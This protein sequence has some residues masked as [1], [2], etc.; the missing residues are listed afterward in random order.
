MALVE[1]EDVTFSYRPGRPVLQAISFQMDPGERVALLGPNGAGKSTL[2][3]H[4]NG[5]VRGEGLVRIAGL[6]VGSPRL[7][8]IRSQ[9]GL[10]FQDPDDQLFCSTVLQDVAYGLR[11]QGLSE[12][13]IENR[14]RRALAEV[15]LSELAD[16]AP[17]ELSGGEKKRAALATVLS[18]EPCLL[19]IDEPTAGLDARARRGVI[20]LLRSRPQAMVVATHDLDLVEELLP[21][22]LILDQGRLHGDFSSAELL[23]DRDRLERHGIIA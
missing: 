13:E 2:L 20:E 9:V 23:K 22:S 1:F 10:V 18:M 3:L 4:F 11:F 21:R 12:D 6:E 19:V 8:Q 14:A 16:R 17:H 7:A 5:L 15:G